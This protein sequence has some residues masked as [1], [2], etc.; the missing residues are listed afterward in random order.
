MEKLSHRRCRT[1][2]QPYFISDPAQEVIAFAGLWSVWERPGAAPGALR[3][4]ALIVDLRTGSGS[5]DRELQAALRGLPREHEGEQ[6]A[7]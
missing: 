4:M 1:P 3:R 5:D 7:Q 6:R 2:R